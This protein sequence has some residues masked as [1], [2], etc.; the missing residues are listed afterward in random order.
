MTELVLAIAGTF[1]VAFAIGWVARYFFG[2]KKLNDA[3]SQ[4]KRIL[5]EAEREGEELKKAKILEAKDEW[6]TQRENFER[7]TREQRAELQR[8][9]KRLYQREMNIDRKADLLK[10]KEQEFDQ[11]ERDLAAFRKELQAKQADLDRLIQEENKKLEEVSGLTREEA[12][13]VLINQMKQQAEEEAAQL[14]KEIQEQARLTA[15]REAKEVV[16]QA[17]QRA[18]TSHAV[19]TTVSVVHL[20]AD[21]MKGR[22]IGREGRNIRSFEMETGVEVVVDDTPEAILLSSFDPVR[23]EIAKIAM[24][25]LIADGRIHPGRIEDVVEKARVEFQERIQEIGEQAMMETGVH[26]LHPDLVRLLGKLKYRTTYGQNVLQHSIEVSHLAGLM[27]AQLG[28][29]V[30]QAKRAGLLHDIGKAVENYTEG[31]LSEIGVD[32]ARKYGESAVIQNAIEAFEENVPIISPISVLVQA[33]DI[34]SSSR[35]GARREILEK[36]IQRLEKIE[37]LAKE[38]AGVEKA[39]AIQAGREIRVIV[40]PEKVSDAEAERLALQI[41]ERIQNEMEYPGQIKITVIREYR[42]EDYAK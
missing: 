1:V 16:I 29:D 11:I 19:E 42:A 4:A 32:I 30:Y 21:E 2:K 40:E 12:K 33:A 39:Y 31:T 3:E 18:A 24:E 28:L 22:I 36:Y 10:K 34:I 14:I 37:T 20:P 13:Q 5:E 27:A 41:A 7:E 26:G 25:K 35:P 17:I 38:F 9:E 23:R 15:H 6:Y 8:M